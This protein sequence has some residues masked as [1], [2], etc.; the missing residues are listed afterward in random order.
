MFVVLVEGYFGNWF[1]EDYMDDIIFF[2]EKKKYVKDYFLSGLRRG[3]F[4]N[5]R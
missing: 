2:L 4:R 5:L 1:M 3:F